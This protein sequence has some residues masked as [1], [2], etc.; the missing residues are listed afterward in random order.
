[1]MA[2]ELN[3]EHNNQGF[4]SNSQKTVFTL[5]MGS[6]KKNAY[7]WVPLKVSQSKMSH[8]H[9]YYN[10]ILQI[11]HR[12]DLSQGLIKEERNHQTG[13]TRKRT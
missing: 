1:M 4:S 7:F 9:E 10:L 2:N 6:C 8:K 5:K 13:T 12:I 11:T 3:T